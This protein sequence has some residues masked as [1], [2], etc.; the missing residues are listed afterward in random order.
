MRGQEFTEDGRETVRRQIGRLHAAAD[1]L[2]GA[3]DNGE[4]TLDEQL[5]HLLKGE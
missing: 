3:L 4:S 2:E 1:W 5:V